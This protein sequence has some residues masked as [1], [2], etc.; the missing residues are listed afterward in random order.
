MQ[1]KLTLQFV[2]TAAVVAPLL[3]VVANVLLT[4]IP[5]LPG[6]PP[7]GI[8]RALFWLPAVVAVVL[9]QFLPFRSWSA[10]AFLTVVFGG[11]M[12]AVLLMA[13]LFGACSFGDCL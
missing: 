8:G 11:A 9:F 12:F 2:P 1:H 5:G 3:L 6:H 4:Y 10:R 7:R 13:Y